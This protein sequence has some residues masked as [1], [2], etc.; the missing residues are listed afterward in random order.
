MEA[1]AKALIAKATKL[2]PENHDCGSAMT[3]SI[4]CLAHDLAVAYDGLMEQYKAMPEAEREIVTELTDTITALRK[5]VA[6]LEKRLGIDNDW[7]N[8]EG[9][10]IFPR[11]DND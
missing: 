3:M 5:R 7:V 1:D 6:E 9:E 10:P 8:G 2:H 11:A 4:F